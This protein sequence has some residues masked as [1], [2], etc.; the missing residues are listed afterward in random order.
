M[1]STDN[2]DGNDGCDADPKVHEPVAELSGFKMSTDIDIGDI[3]TVS[4]DS[5]R[6][7]I[8]IEAK[9]SEEAK[10]TIDSN[11]DINC[12]DAKD[13][14]ADKE[15]VDVDTEPFDAKLDDEMP[16]N[17]LHFKKQ[18]E[19]MLANHP[20][21][22][23]LRY[24]E[25]RDEYHQR[26]TVGDN[27]AELINLK[28]DALNGQPV[29]VRDYVK[30]KDRFV[31]RF[32][33]YKAKNTSRLILRKN[34]MEILPIPVS[35]AFQQFKDN[36]AA[37]AW[38]KLTRGGT[39]FDSDVLIS[40]FIAQQFPLYDPK[41]KSYAFVNFK[42]INKRY[43]QLRSD[44]IREARAK[45]F[46]V[47]KTDSPKI[48]SLLYSMSFVRKLHVVRTFSIPKTWQMQKWNDGLYVPLPV[49]AVT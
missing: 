18:W 16:G 32:L 45:G 49:S 47:T 6:D 15:S 34:V 3:D 48:I 35:K 36:V 22:L 14:A 17:A 26:W 30:D 41:T 40:A 37:P 27:D 31:V 42:K 7:D 5:A 43:Q 11:S 28:N 38:D 29:I 24:P 25:T 2:D 21:E 44:T 4:G 20:D 9:Q 13:E 12:G 8:K 23:F 33:D 10:V 1:D 19:Y 46:G 39:S